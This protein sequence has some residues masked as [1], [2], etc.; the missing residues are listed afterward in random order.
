MPKWIDHIVVRV[1]DINEALENYEGKLGMKASKGPD[2]IPEMGM[3][4]AILPLGDDGR[5]IELAEPLGEG[6]AIGGALERY[7]EGV[8]LVALAVDDLAEAK[9]EMQGNGARII[10][11]GTQVFVHPRD[12]HGVMYQLIERK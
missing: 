10:E 4:R 5:F 6:G 9:A 7:G 2:A 8:H 1:K 11:A 3:T 12:G